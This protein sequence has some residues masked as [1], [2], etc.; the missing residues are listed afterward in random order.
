MLF[1]KP[2]K[3]QDGRYFLKISTDDGGRVMHQVNNVK[4]YTECLVP[5]DNTL[6]SDIDEAIVTQAKESKVAWFGKEI[7]DETV[8]SAYQK[9]ISLEGELSASFASIKGDVVTTCY[10]TQKNKVELDTIT[11][12]TPVDVLLELVGLVFTKR[13]FEPVWKMIQV[14]VK[15]APKPRFPREYLFKDDVEPEEE[16]I[17]L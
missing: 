7:S 8:T 17:D 11:A 4:F 10:D 14:R 2:S 15:S 9:S 16:D 1:D 6:F 13:S 3:L 5:S 12:G